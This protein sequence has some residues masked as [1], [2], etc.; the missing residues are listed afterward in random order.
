MKN[1]KKGLVVVVILLFISVSVI[2]STGIFVDN[3]Q[4]QCSKLYTWDRPSRVLC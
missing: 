3:N 4:S 2:P 1:G